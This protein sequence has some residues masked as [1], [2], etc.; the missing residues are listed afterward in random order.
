M[1]HSITDVHAHYDEAVFDTDRG[2]VLRT[3]RE[4]GVCAIVNSG[5]S[6]PSSRR[7][8]D[9]AKRFEG[10]YA[11]V[12]VFPLEAYNVP[13][14]WLEQISDMAEEDGCVAVGE[15]G[16]DYH[17]EDGAGPTYAQRETQKNVFRAQLELARRKG[18]PVVIHD[19]DADED[20][21]RLLA[22][23]PCPGMIHRFFSRAEY[24]FQLLE[25]GLSLGIGPAV[26]Y[27]N[28]GELVQVVRQMPLERLLLE[29]DAPFLPSARF[30]GKRAPSDMI[31]DVCEVV[32]QIRGDVTPQEVA[33]AARENARRM[34]GI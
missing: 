3:L 15:I 1:L 16:L 11:S 10:V 5:S 28:A 14:G 33:L 27:S 7:S 29:T 23:L 24:G 21:I 17:L 20:V 22:E 4:A 30:E 26:T 34:F 2:E 25:M 18:M 32:A 12:G 31:A 19:R 13:S 6:V 9:L 8:L